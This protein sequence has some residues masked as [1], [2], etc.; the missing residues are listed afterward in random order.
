ETLAEL[1]AVGLLV[2]VGTLALPFADGRGVALGAYAAC[3]VQSGIDWQWQLPAVTLAG[4]FC[5]VATLDAC[6]PARVRLGTPS[7]TAGVAAAVALGGLAFA[8]LIGNAAIARGQDAVRVGDE[9]AAL[10]AAR[11]ARRWAPWS[12]EPWRIL[13]EARGG[14]VR[15][16][17][18]AVRL[19]PSDW[20]L[21]A[22]LARNAS[23]VEARRAASEAAR[24]N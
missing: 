2:V 5:G 23:G 21:W 11:R 7:R 22:E 18:R 10:A 9:P 20:S 8:G 24:L 17:R 13:S 12:A 19:D 6:S 14:D 4:L 1:G 3:V 16:L 15:A